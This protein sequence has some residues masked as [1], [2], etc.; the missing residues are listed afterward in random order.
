M[1]IFR[2][3]IPRRT[4]LRG[5]GATLALPLLDSM[6]PALG[7]G[8]DKA[9]RPATRLAFVYVPNGQI[10]SKWTPATDGANFEIPAI[11]EPLASFRDQFLVLTGLDHDMAD[12][13]PGEGE[14][15]P[16]DRAS[17]SYLT[18]VHVKREGVAGISVDQIAA[19]ELGRQTQ[20]MSLELGLDVNNVIGQCERNWNCAF[21]HTLSWRTPTTPLPVENQPRALFERLFGDTNSTDTA[22]RLARIQKDASILDSVR[23]A[24]AHLI[25][26]LG[27]GDGAKLSEYLDAIRDVERRIQKAEEQ[28]SR[29]LPT[30]ERPAG[31]PSRFDEHIQ[32]L[33]DLLVLAYQ[34]DLTRVSTFMIGREMSTKAYPEIGLADPYHPLTHH[35]GDP[36]KIEKATQ[37]NV[38]H[39]Q[40]FA[41]F[42]EKLRSTPDGDGSLLD[43][44]IIVYGAGLGDGNMHLPIDLPIVVAGGGA[45]KIKGGRHLKYPE[46]TPLANLYLRLMEMVGLQVE[47]FGDSSGKINLLS[48]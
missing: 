45:G 13:F 16:H 4:F 37:V 22:E 32:L 28:S 31:I 11:L 20:L 38:Y 1:M 2:K 24:A 7:A 21:R 8:I 6:I 15:A 40:M 9:A 30:V 41:Y 10:M 48:V 44:S 17:A 29:E 39:T 42:L 23:E 33:F 18:G 12:P 35:Q 3:S 27:A 46:G 34:T 25:G 14:V 5:V 26:E 43:H 19:K 47:K 36:V